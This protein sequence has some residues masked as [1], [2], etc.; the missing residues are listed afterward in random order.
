MAVDRD[1][2]KETSIQKGIEKAMQKRNAA[3]CAKGDKVT[4]ATDPRRGSRTSTRR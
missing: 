3:T 4:Y 2:A 1:K